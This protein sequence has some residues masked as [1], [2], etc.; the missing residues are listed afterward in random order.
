MSWDELKNNAPNFNLDDSSLPVESVKNLIDVQ[1]NKQVNEAKST[2]YNPVIPPSGIFKFFNEFAAS[3]KDVAFWVYSQ[4]KILHMGGIGVEYVKVH[5]DVYEDLLL[6]LDNTEEYPKYGI[7]CD[8]MLSNN[9]MVIKISSWNVY[10]FPEEE[11]NE[12]I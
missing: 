3:D 5:P 1:K 11:S 7:D 4:I 9:E 10:D 6:M 2:Q 8:S 12:S